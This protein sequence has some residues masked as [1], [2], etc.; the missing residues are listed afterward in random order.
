MNAI[1]LIFKG[2]KMGIDALYDTVFEKK[3]PKW[4][5]WIFGIVTMP[6]NIL[7]AVLSSRVRKEVWNEVEDRLNQ[8]E[9]E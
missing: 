5:C 4:V 1:K 9:A 6:L 8:E 3:V 2:M 7:V